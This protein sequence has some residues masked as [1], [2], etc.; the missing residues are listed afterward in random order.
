MIV[1]EK[2]KSKKVNKRSYKAGEKRNFLVSKCFQELIQSNCTVMWY[3]HWWLKNQNGVIVH[4]GSS[5]ITYTNYDNV[6]AADLAQRIFKTGKKR[7]SFGVNN[8]AI[9]LF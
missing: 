3:P 5:A 9:S 8:I 4:I 6:N 2:K 7:R 1:A